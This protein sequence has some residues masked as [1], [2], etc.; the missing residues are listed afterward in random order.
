MIMSNACI[1][2]LIKLKLGFL[3]N[4]L[5]YNKCFIQMFY[6][7]YNKRL[8]VGMESYIFILHKYTRK[9]LR[10]IIIQIQ[11]DL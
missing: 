2:H 4:F 1:V 11:Y 7:F 10:R 8:K 9:L 3:T 6:T 5:F